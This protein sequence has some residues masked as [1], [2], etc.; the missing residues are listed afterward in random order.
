MKASVYR[1][2]CRSYYTI[3]I[4]ALIELISAATK[5]QNLHEGRWVAALKATTHL[6]QEWTS[7]VHLLHRRPDDAVAR[8]LRHVGV[9]GRGVP[10][11]DH[12]PVVQPSR[13]T[14]LDVTEQLLH[15]HGLLEPGPDSDVHQSSLRKAVNFLTYDTRILKICNLLLP[16][17][18]L[19]PTI[20]YNYLVFGSVAQ[21]VRA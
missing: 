5:L 12:S 19:L 18:E 7:D 9:F 15:V 13:P 17:L 21:L 8:I 14:L 20:C 6:E 10:P 2:V 16:A 3:K 11:L 4:F 1:V